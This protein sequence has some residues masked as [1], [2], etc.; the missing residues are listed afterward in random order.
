VLS[1]AVAGAIAGTGAALAGVPSA[2]PATTSYSVAGELFG[3]S[4]TSAGSAWAVGCS[5]TSRLC[6]HTLI[7]RWNGRKWAPVLSP[8]PL[9]GVLTAVSAVSADNAWAVG[10]TDNA[11]GL[12]PRPLVMHWNGRSWSRQANLPASYGVLNSVAVS[13]GSVWATGGIQHKESLVGPALFL[14]RTGGRWYLVPAEGPDAILSSVAVT[15]RDSAWAFG[16][17][18]SIP[19]RSKDTLDAILLRWNG[20]VWKPAAF[21]GGDQDVLSVAAGP[22]GG[23][24]AVGL[25]VNSKS[26][27]DSPLALRWTG[28]TWRNVPVPATVAPGLE[29]VTVAPNGTAWATGASAIVETLGGTK[30][31]IIKAAVIRWTGKAWARTGLPHAGDNALLSAVAATSAGNAWAVGVAYPVSPTSTA[32]KT[33]ILHWNGKAWG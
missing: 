14:H 8:R 19:P 2:Q 3:V 5:G 9:T 10:D 7:L 21:Q 25:S 23:A 26:G 24:W 20:A 30:Q 32:I 29:A 11:A 4:A 1:L 13:G 18:Y 31:T 15:G 12:S 22:D 16:Q 28:K 33:L 6:N 27:A 17:S